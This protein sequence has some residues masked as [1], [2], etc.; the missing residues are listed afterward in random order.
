ML[1]QLAEAIRRN[2]AL[3]HGT[4]S[5]MLPRLGPAPRLAGRAV[6]DGF[7]I[8]GNVPSDTL[9]ASAHEALARL[10]QGEAGLAV[11]PLCGTN[12]AV[13]GMLAGLAAVL[14]MGRKPRVERLP[15]VFTASMFA[16]VAA[17]PLGR[18]VQKY[19]TTSPAVQTVEITHVRRM[20]G[21]FVHKVQTVG[22]RPVS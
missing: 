4:V 2:H 19:V 17:Q 18:L 6:S 1:R 14:A 11:T 9:E 10:K 12:I 16:V 13:A 3:E 8:Y 7:Y 21:G 20:A 15:S 22:A 5:I